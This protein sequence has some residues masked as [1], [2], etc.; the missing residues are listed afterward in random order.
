VKPSTRSWSLGCE[1]GS[2]TASENAGG[3][4]KMV[5]QVPHDPMTHM[6]AVYMSDI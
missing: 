1:G 4:E 3:K 6:L 2:Q 5:D